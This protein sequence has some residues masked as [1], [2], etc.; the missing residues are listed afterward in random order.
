VEG[1]AAL[2][3]LVRPY[4]APLSLSPDLHKRLR[5]APLGDIVRE[6]LFP[7]P[8]NAPTTDLRGGGVRTRAGLLLLRIG[9]Y[10]GQEAG[11]SGSCLEDFWGWRT[12]AS[13]TYR[14]DPLAKGP[15]IPLAI[16]SANFS[17]RPRRI[18][19]DEFPSSP[20]RARQMF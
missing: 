14:L 1:W 2:D 12:P 6:R 19:S 5:G 15:V 9:T 3:S 8:R 20:E 10:L 16:L 17:P 4:P 7:R 13:A 11:L 18:L